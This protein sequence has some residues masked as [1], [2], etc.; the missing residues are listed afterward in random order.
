[1][2]SNSAPD[3]LAAFEALQSEAADFEPDIRKREQA[4]RE[5]IKREVS[6]GSGRKLLDPLTGLGA[7]CREMWP[8][9]PFGLEALIKT[10]KDI[11][12]EAHDHE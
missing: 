11:E 10:V 8:G 4:L 6:T 12:Q 2:N 7:Y 9:K 5:K 1:M 3:L